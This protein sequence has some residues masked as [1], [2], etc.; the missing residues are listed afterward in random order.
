VAVRAEAYVPVLTSCLSGIRL[1][2]GPTPLFL[3]HAQGSHP[4]GITPDPGAERLHPKLERRPLGGQRQR[5]T[6]TPYPGPVR[7]RNKGFKNSA[8]GSATTLLSSNRWYFA[9][10]LFDGLVKPTQQMP[11]ARQTQQQA[12]TEAER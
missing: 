9:P 3:P 4:P 6:Q 8:F 7:I 11:D 1:G 2:A 12:A 5:A 10:Q